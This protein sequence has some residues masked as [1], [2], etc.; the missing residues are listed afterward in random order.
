MKTNYVFY[1][2]YNLDELEE[3]ARESLLINDE[4]LTEEDITDDMIWEE[5][6][7]IDDINREE[8]WAELDNIF[9]GNYLAV[10]TCGRWDGTYDGG[11]V[12][13]TFKELMS[14]FEHCVYFKIWIDNN[15]FYVE[16]SHH[17]GTD[18]VEVKEITD[19]GF[20]YYE[21]WNYGYDKRT[22]REVHRKMFSDSH[23]THLI[24]I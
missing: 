15:H 21:N 5:I 17:D 19:R 2:N 12:F 20:Q 16:G 22:E 9:N 3:E 4:D 1:D 6:Y 23:Y 11:F 24:K 7:F 14:R 18:M 13:K 8:T 10:G